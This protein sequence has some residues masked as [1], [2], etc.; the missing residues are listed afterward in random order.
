MTDTKSARVHCAN[1]ECREPCIYE[2]GRI[3][4]KHC[5]Y[6]GPRGWDK[7]SKKPKNYCYAAGGY[8]IYSE[9][10]AIRLHN[11]IVG[12]GND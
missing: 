9:S 12:D 7:E 2:G 10:E 4:C 5:G 8:Y 11:L 6:C 1:R 3:V